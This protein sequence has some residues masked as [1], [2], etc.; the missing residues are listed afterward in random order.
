MLAMNIKIARNEAGLTMRE[1]GDAIGVS[2]QTIANW[3]TGV[4]RP[5]LKKLRDIANL[6]QH[7]VEQ[8][9][10]TGD[11]PMAVIDVRS[12]E[13]LAEATRRSVESIVKTA[14]DN[15]ETTRRLADTNAKLAEH[16]IELGKA[17]LTLQK[18]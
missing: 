5:G 15:A 8:L 12:G 10:G 2:R 14:K 9:T 6:T 7:S 13:D 17:L 3:E 16:V 18:D 11:A 4:T 1:L